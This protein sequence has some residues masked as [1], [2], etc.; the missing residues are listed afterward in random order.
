MKRGA[1]HRSAPFAFRVSNCRL[2]FG[3]REKCEAGGTVSDNGFAFDELPPVIQEF[4]RDIPTKEEFEANAALGGYGVPMQK[5]KRFIPENPAK[6]G[7]NR[8]LDMKIK[9]SGDVAFY[10]V[11]EGRF[12]EAWGEMVYGLGRGFSGLNGARPLIR[13]NR[14][15]CPRELSRGAFE[16]EKGLQF[17][18]HWPGCGYWTVS[19]KALDIIREFA[20]SSIEYVEIDFVDS[21]KFPPPFERMYFF[22]VVRREEQPL[23]LARTEADWERGIVHLKGRW[24]HRPIGLSRLTLRDDLPEHLHLFRHRGF[25]FISRELI[26]AL[27]SAGVRGM[28]YYDYAQPQMKSIS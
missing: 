13:A 16:Y 6:V 25:T 5:V 7:E 8:F 19:Q 26:D 28:I 20:E 21:D 9:L 2:T 4:I 3:K 15:E 11:L 24:V 17:Y 23:D 12:R 10:P 22:D 18:D 14:K 27:L 1:P